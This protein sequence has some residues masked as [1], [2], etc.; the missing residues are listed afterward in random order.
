MGKYEPKTKKTKA[1]VA[2]F[3]NSIEDEKKRKQSKELN[4]LFK[5]ITK[6]QP[7]M[8]GASIVG[9]GEYHYKSKAGSEGDWPATGFSPRKTA[10]TLY[11]MPGYN[12]MQDD[13]KKL[14][15]VKNGKSC[16]YIKDLD[17]IH[18]PTL[19]KMIK[20]GFTYMKKEHGVK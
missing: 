9:Y 13:L 11:I 10:L 18:M 14:G 17:K 12:L 20:K 8:W 4:K 7:K 19:K 15:D 3:L 1:S 2:Q 16:L 5:E 6:K